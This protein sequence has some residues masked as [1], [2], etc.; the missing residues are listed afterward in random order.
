MSF[1]HKNRSRCSRWKVWKV[2]VASKSGGVGIPKL[3]FAS[4]H[5]REAA[6]TCSLRGTSTAL[7]SA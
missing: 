2:G 3:D 6:S 5:C 7:L 4:C 1:K